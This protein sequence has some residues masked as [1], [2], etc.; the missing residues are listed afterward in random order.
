MSAN[1]G[2]I[3]DEEKKIK[4][5]YSLRS[6]NK[7]L[8]EEYLNNLEKIQEENKINIIWQQ[9][10]DGFEPDYNSDL[11]VKV[12]TNTNDIADVSTRLNDISTRVDAS[13]VALQAKDVEIDASIDRLD[14]SVSA[15][16]SRTITGESNTLTNAND[17]YVNVSAT[18]DDQGNVTIDS[19]VQLANPIEGET[20]ADATGLAT[21]GGV[22][23]FLAWDVIG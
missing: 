11:V 15:L 23:D 3:R 9:E 19:S 20:H 21:D 6:N 13:I 12:D 8:K 16:E 18:T 10:L 4:I 17:E 1:L 14:A 5:E 7:K 2:A 22:K